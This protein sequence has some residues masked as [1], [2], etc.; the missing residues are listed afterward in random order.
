LLDDKPDLEANTQNG[1]LE[2]IV[3]KEKL[4]KRRTAPRNL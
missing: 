1:T 2:E 4:K 3:E